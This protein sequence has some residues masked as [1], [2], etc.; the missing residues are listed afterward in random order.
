LP[1][2]AR[3]LQEKY[4]EDISRYIARLSVEQAD[5]IRNALGNFSGTFANWAGKM[6]SDVL[7][8]GLALLNVLSLVFLTPIVAFYLL[9]DWNRL[10]ERLKDLLPRRHEQVILE[11]L[12][13]I[14]RTLSGFIRG[15]TNVCLIMATY[16]GLMLTLAGLNF[17][18]GLGIMTGCLLFIPFVGFA[19]CFTLSMTVALFQFGVQPYLMAIAAVYLCGMFLEGSVLTPRLVGNQVGLHPLWIIFGMLTGATL[20]GFV[21]VL[22]S[23]PVTSVVGVL[24]RFAIQRY[25]ESG[26]YLGK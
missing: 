4:S 11:Q 2:Y 7:K 1:D 12:R 25:R 9:R 26:L 10:V 14:D 21:G 6:F 16:Y 13:A 24:V 5:S 15:Q 20:F 22:I 3:P 23:V 8:S 18:L 19:T 17:G